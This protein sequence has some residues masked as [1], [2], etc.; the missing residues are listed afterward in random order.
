MAITV[1]NLRIEPTIESEKGP[2]VFFGHLKVKLTCRYPLKKV[3]KFVCFCEFYTRG[4]QSI[5]S[6]IDSI[7]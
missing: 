1:V 6:I 2:V 4:S 7:R 5:I 3:S